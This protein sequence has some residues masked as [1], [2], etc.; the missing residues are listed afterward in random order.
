MSP[1]KRRLLLTLSFLAFSAPAWAEF[2]ETTG[3]RQI[4]FNESRRTPP[5]NERDPLDDY[6]RVH[7]WFVGLT[8]GASLL[9]PQDVQ[10]LLGDRTGNQGAGNFGLMVGY[11][12]HRR[13]IFGLTVSRESFDRNT[14][15]ETD[16]NAAGFV[17]RYTYRGIPV[18]LTYGYE[19][20]ATDG[21][22]IEMLAPPKTR[23]SL[24][25][26]GG[27]GASFSSNINGHNQFHERVSTRTF[28]LPGVSGGLDM[29][30]TRDGLPFWITL[31]GGYRLFQ[32]AGLG[33]SGKNLSLNG[34]FFHLRILMYVN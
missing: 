26:S 14:T 13:G 18:F 28:T 1:S 4:R 29:S 22:Q 20:L 32:S 31:G 6:D 10:T 19:L 9:K 15:V 34:L 12:P 30:V 23:L 2:S 5:K 11:R 17:G 7:S 8:V 25:A 24:I 3:E 33:S 16:A 21:G 27:L